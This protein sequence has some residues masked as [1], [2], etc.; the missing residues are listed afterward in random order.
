M[1]THQTLDGLIH[2]RLIK[3]MI[4]AHW[5]PSAAELAKRLEIPPSE[6]KSSLQRLESNHGLVL[7][8]HQIQLEQVQ[9]IIIGDNRQRV[10]EG[11]IRIV[12]LARAHQRAALGAVGFDVALVTL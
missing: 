9:H 6:I 3:E 4:D 2:Q 11:Q 8:P 12:E 10:V 5:C 1:T 7:H